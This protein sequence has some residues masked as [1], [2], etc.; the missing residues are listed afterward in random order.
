MLTLILGPLFGHIESRQGGSI[1]WSLKIPP[2]GGRTLFGGGI[3]PNWCPIQP[4]L[5][6][7]GPERSRSPPMTHTPLCPTLRID[8][9]RCDSAAVQG[10]C[11]GLWSAWFYVSPA[12]REKVVLPTKQDATGVLIRGFCN[13]AFT[14]QGRQ[15]RGTPK[16]GE[17]CSN[18][19][20]QFLKPNLDSTFFLSWHL[21]PTSRKSLAFCIFVVKRSN[22][23]GDHQKIF[24]VHCFHT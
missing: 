4:S 19:P 24:Q 15:G 18:H 13:P 10:A 20:S 11:R 2:G 7:P 1:I 6:A 17:G 16:R 9:P 21:L 8:T 22:R 23:L 14:P 12:R 3:H 5:P